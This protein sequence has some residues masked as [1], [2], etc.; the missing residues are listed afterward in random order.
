MVGRPIRRTDFWVKTLP[1]ILLWAGGDGTDYAI[2]LLKGIIEVSV[3][4]AGH[5][6][7]F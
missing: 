1:C 6:E 4:R 2:Y 3:H 7:R 5:W